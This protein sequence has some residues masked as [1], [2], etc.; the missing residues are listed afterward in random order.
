MSA[1]LLTI[2]CAGRPTGEGEREQVEGVAELGLSGT[3]I[4]AELARQWAALGLEPSPALDDAEFLRRVSLDLIGRIPSATEVER[5]LADERPDKRAR[6]VDA[7]LASEG[8]ADYWAGIWADA[9]LTTDSKV[10]RAAREPL[11]DYLAAALAERRSWATVVEQLLTA[12]GEL[13]VS[14]RNR[15]RGGDAG[16]TDP[17]TAALAYLAGHAR[18][19]VPRAEQL[20]DLSATTARVFLGA[21]IECARCHDHPYE[22]SFTQADFWA[23]AA[24]FGQTRVRVR[25]ADDDRVVVVEDRPRAQLRFGLPEP[26]SEPGADLGEPPARV[27]APRYMGA[28]VAIDGD[29]RR[30]ELAAAI[31]ADPRFAEATAGQ[32]W[33]RLLGRGIVEPWDELLDVGDERPALLLLLAAEF[34]AHDHDLAALIR[35]IVLSQAYQRSSRGPASDAAQ[36]RAAEAGFARAIVRPLSGEQLLASVITATGIEQLEGRRLRRRVR[37]LEAAARREYAFVFGDDELDEAAT[38]ADVFTGNVP[39]ALLLLNGGLTNHGVV[40]RVGGSLDRILAA[41]DDTDARLIGLW[42][43]VYGRRPSI[44]ELE[45]GRA[46]VGDGRDPRDWEDLMFAALYSSEFASNH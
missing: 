31:V 46:A 8:F 25:Q 13:D 6:Q 20:G 23:Q 42:A 11:T 26:G 15:G 17:D 12:E 24:L 2:A 7:L 4:D 27:V 45:L 22:S 3:V 18:R 38:R 30:A 29:D 39:Q 16:D 14:R 5:F 35:T 41:S 44:A 10:A 33:A 21:R 32:V 19:G 34:R 37:K 43:T 36:V 40:A 28:A 9:L 1:S